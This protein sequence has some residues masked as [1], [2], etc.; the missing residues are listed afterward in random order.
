LTTSMMLGG[1]IGST[2]IFDMS[3][4]SS[5]SNRAYEPHVSPGKAT[6]HRAHCSQKG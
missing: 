5:S 6:P 1:S 3:S 2:C 4:S